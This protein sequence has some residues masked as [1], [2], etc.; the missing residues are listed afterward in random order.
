MH[1]QQISSPTEG[2]THDKVSWLIVLSCVCTRSDQH[3]LFHYFDHTFNHYIISVR[4]SSLR[5]NTLDS[6]TLTN[7]SNKIIAPARDELTN[8]TRRGRDEHTNETDS[9]DELTRDELT[10]ATSLRTKRTHHRDELTRQTQQDKS[11]RPRHACRRARPVPNV[12]DAHRD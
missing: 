1:Q 7:S 9:R 12:R 3:L 4:H 6:P 10:Y 11:P 2:Y 8:A 5:F